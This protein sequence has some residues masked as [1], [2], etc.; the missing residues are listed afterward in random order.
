MASQVI[1]IAKAYE[2]GNGKDATNS[3]E[4]GAA[5]LLSNCRTLRLKQGRAMA[6]AFSCGAV[7]NIYTIAD[8]NSM[9]QQQRNGKPWGDPVPLPIF[10]AEEVGG[11]CCSKD[12]VP[13]V[14]LSK[15]PGSSEILPCNATSAA[16]FSTALVY[17]VRGKAGPILPHQGQ[18]R[19]SHRGASRT[20]PKVE[21][22][23]CV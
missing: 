3:I 6:E 18:R 23:L 9:Y 1:P 20:V 4:L 14:L 19:V 13:C 15:P 16:R 21:R 12:L 11:E 7:P 10:F 5:T 22:L 17:Q 2:I 8:F